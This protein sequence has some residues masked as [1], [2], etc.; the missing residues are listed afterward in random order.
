[1]QRAAAPTALAALFLAAATLPAAT[2]AAPILGQHPQAAPHAGQQVQPDRLLA[3]LGALPPH[4][5]GHGSPEDVAGLRQAEQWLIARLGDLGYQPETQDVPRPRRLANLTPPDAPTPRNIWVD[6][7]ATIQPP[8]ADAETPGQP[9]D[10]T[11]DA[12]EANAGPIVVM[13]HLDAVRGSPGVDD[14]ATGVA[15][16]LELAAVLRDRDR[17]RP[18]RLLFTTLEE[19]GLVGAEHHVRQTILPAIARGHPRVSGALSV[20]MIGYYSD[21]PGSQRSPLEAIP[22]LVEVPDRGD[23]LALVGLSAHRA[24]T[25]ALAHAMRQAQPEAPVVVADFFAFPVPDI[26]RSD[27]ARFLAVGLPGAML[28]DTA[29][30]RNPHYHKPTDTID[31]IDHE[32]YTRAVRQLAGAVDLLASWRSWPEPPPLPTATEPGT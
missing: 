22:G 1:M 23:F 9:G 15:A 8:T 21:E 32:R 31:T 17:R 7:P 25:G 20:D 26:M 10:A 5:A 18:I 12:P 14:N 13:A 16:L 19:V 3:N 6:L 11:K 27:H 29:N 30:F 24:F 2:T 4:R 28:T